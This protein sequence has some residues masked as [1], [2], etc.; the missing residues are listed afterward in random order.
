M[1]AVASGVSALAVAT[2]LSLAFGAGAVSA[3]PQ[4]NPGITRLQVVTF[5]VKPNKVETFLALEK[6]EVVPALKKAGIK[7]RQTYRTVVGDANEFQVR[8]IVPG[9]EIY[10]EPGALERALGAKKAAELRDRLDA[11]LDSVHVQF[12]N[13]VNEFF[14]D[15]G[16]APVQFASKYRPLP[17]K[18]FAYTQFYREYMNPVAKEA[19]AKGTF[20][21]MDYTVSQ[22]GGEWGLITLNMYYDSFAPLDGE[23]PIAKTLG[24]EKTRE[25]LAHGQGLIDPIEWIVRRRVADL[26]F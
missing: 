19:K 21:G 11:C 5:R 15:P 10:D 2:G 22:H 12:E 25:M 9:F 26:S 16:N 17:G 3:Q 18:S 7:S 20:A 24:P 1:K 23:P 8:T 13:R 4:S 14:V 6:G